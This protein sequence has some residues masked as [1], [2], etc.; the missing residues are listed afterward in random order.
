MIP[1]ESLMVGAKNLRSPEYMQFTG[2]VDAQGV[3]IYEGDIVRVADVY[4]SVNFGC[5]VEYE[6][7]EVSAVDRGWHPFCD[8][9]G[10]DCEYRYSTEDV[11]V[12][13]NKFESPDLLNTHNSEP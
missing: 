13:G 8:S 12:I 5:P 10:I 7:I 9:G 2:L 3:E 4:E 6:I 11:V 1:H